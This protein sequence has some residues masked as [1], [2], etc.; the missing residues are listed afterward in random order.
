MTRCEYVRTPP[1]DQSCLLSANTDWDQPAENVTFMA[2]IG[3][4]FWNCYTKKII[5]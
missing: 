1:I 4:V 2:N 3:Y 5:H